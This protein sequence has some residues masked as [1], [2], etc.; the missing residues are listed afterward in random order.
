MAIDKINTFSDALVTAAKE[1]QRAQAET[2]LVL[3]SPYEVD[4]ISVLFADPDRLQA[5]VEYCKEQ[6]IEHFNRVDSDR[7][8]RIDGPGQFDVRF[9]FLR[10]PTLGWRIEAMC[11][12]DGQAPLHEAHLDR[13]GDGCIV[14]ASYKLPEVEAYRA[15]RRYLS[16]KGAILAGEYENSY[17]RFA[18]WGSGHNPYMKPRVNLR[19]VEVPTPVDNAGEQVAID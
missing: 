6:G 2:S 1:Q 13:L 19:D 5:F 15:H 9:E 4:E 12:L 7:M 16:D 18:Y 3:V 14:H 8:V 11:V 17:G 10:F